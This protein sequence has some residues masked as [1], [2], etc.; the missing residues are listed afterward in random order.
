MDTMA[1]FQFFHRDLRVIVIFVQKP[2]A[3]PITN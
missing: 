3:R 1:L 2:S